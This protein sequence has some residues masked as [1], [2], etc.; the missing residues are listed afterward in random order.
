M[1]VED[2]FLRWG[3]DRGLDLDI[4]LVAKGTRELNIIDQNGIV[5]GFD[6]EANDV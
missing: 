1:G 4:T 2:N 6:A 3:L 5:Y